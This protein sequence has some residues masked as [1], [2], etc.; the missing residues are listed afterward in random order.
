MEPLNDN[1]V[2]KLCSRFSL[3]VISLMLPKQLSSQQW[4][5]LENSLNMVLTRNHLSSEKSA[6]R[7]LQAKKAGRSPS[8]SYGGRERDG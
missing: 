8:S 1:F 2:S 3:A 5:N 4:L 6:I 7:E